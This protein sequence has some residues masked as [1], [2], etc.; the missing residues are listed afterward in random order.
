VKY[1]KCYQDEEQKITIVLFIFSEC[2][3]HS[4]ERNLS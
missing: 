3:V 1:A 2:N 4:C